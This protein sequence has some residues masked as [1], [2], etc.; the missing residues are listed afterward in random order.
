LQPLSPSTAG[1]VATL[2]SVSVETTTTTLALAPTGSNAEPGPAAS[3]SGSTTA[4]VEGAAPSVTASGGLPNQSQPQ[5]ARRNE[6]RGGG[7]VQTEAE[8]EEN[9]GAAPAKALAQ[10]QAAASPLA[11]FVAGLD[12]AFD[13]TRLK[14][15][16]RALFAGASDPRTTVLV[17]VLRVLDS[18]LERWSSVIAAA[19]DPLPRVTVELVRTGVA[20]AHL[21]DAAL[22][23]LEAET[24]LPGVGVGA[25]PRSGT[26]PPRPAVAALGPVSI[27]LAALARVHVDPIRP[28]HDP[29]QRRTRDAT[30]KGTRMTPN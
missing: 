24:V 1:L 7:E 11:R 15:H 26:V 18:L 16:H 25:P 4:E 21:V 2:L 6:E 10:T 28:R 9:E 3:G 12:E 8:E 20:R 14:A 23:A 22:P 27:G 13:R 5:G 29:K 19:A 17:P 30:L